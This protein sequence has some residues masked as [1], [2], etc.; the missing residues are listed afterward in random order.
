MN[1]ITSPIID[2]GLAVRNLENSIAFYRDTVG[3]EEVS[4]FEV[5]EQVAGDAG[6]TGY[7]SFRAQVM[8]LGGTHNGTKIKLIE[9]PDAATRPHTKFIDSVTGVR[10]LTVRV[11]DIDAAVARAQDA[12]VPIQS[13]GPANFK[14]NIWIA[15]IHDPDGNMIE[16]IG[17]KKT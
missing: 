5:P 1:N 10:Y 11:A 8:Q 4:Q 9:F 14:D 17:P 2:I 6:L 7:K 15:I 12:G 13:K 16:L 3:F